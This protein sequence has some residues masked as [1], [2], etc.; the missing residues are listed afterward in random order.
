MVG[1]VTF[2]RDWLKRLQ[3]PN[4]ILCEVFPD[5]ASSKGSLLQLPK[6]IN[7]RTSSG[8]GG[9]IWLQ[10]SLYI[11]DIFDTKIVPKWVGITKG[12]V[13]ISGWAAECMCQVGAW[14]RTCASQVGRWVQ[15]PECCSCLLAPASSLAALCGGSP[16]VA[17]AAAGVCGRFGAAARETRETRRGASRPLA[18]QLVTRRSRRNGFWLRKLSIRR[19]GE[20]HIC[21]EDTD[22]Q[23]THYLCVI[24]RHHSRNLELG[25]KIEQSCCWRRWTWGTLLGRMR[26][27]P[28]SGG[29]VELTP[30][31]WVEHPSNEADHIHLYLSVSL[32]IVIKAEMEK[33]ADIS[34]LFFFGCANILA[35]YAQT[36]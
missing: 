36:S 9:V 15:A 25:K 33:R 2:R 26:G 32:H 11:G 17:K 10:F 1:A 8:G 30:G 14:V 7:F 27:R 18:A 3:F 4:C 23:H 21:I 20:Q 28:C 34:V 12:N 29:W 16:A 24:V 19:I 5:Y 22:I 31:G 13:G 35:V 6:Q